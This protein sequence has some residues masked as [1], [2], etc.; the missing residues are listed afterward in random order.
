M[1]KIIITTKNNNNEIGAKKDIRAAISPGFV[2][3]GTMRPMF[4]PVTV[5]SNC[6]MNSFF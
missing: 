3:L 5:L 1:P 2:S 6:Q 4:F